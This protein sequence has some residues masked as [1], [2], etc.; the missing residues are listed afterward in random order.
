MAKQ[1]LGSIQVKIESSGALHFTRAHALFVFLSDARYKVEIR[2]TFLLY[3]KIPK[4]DPILAP[5]SRF[6]P[7]VPRAWLYLIGL[8]IPSHLT[9][10]ILDQ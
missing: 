5:F 7:S 3:T 8:L 9:F 10:Q 4:F 6:S 1:G 2:A